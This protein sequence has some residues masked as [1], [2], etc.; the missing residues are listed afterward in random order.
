MSLQARLLLVLLSAVLLTTAIATA[1]TYYWARHEIDELFDYHLRQQALTLRDKA[2]MLGTVVVPEPDPDQDFVI[3]AWDWRGQRIYLSHRGVVLPRTAQPGYADLSAAGTDWRVYTVTL[4]TQ[5]VQIAQPMHVRRS[6]ATDAALKILYPLL[7]ILPVLALLIWWL[8]GRALTPL[9]ALARTIAERQPHTLIP[10]TASGLPTEA[11]LMV[12]AL[13]DLIARL[14]D[15]LSRQ[16]EFMADAAHELRTPLTALQLQTQLLERVETAD[17]RAAAIA[18]LKAGVQRASHL[19]ERLLTFTR[20]APESHD[21]E[22]TSVD[23]ARMAHEIVL[24]FEPSARAREQRLQAAISP[25]AQINGNETGL[26]SLLSNLLDNA[27]HSTPAGGVVALDVGDD[28]SVLT[29]RVTDTGPGIPVAE[30]ERIFDRFYRIA[31]TARHGSGLGLAIVKRVV[32]LHHG[33]ITVGSGP[34]G[35]G[36]EFLVR[37]PRSINLDPLSFV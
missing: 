4:G 15:V 36:A 10:I 23:V 37:L 18:E 9:G 2:Y 27:L 11:R 24:R 28:P 14:R 3:Q 6:L 17:A 13:N 16:R 19:I 25:T 20:L 31:G 22:F 33:E 7:A 29:L 30:R 32:D 5:L 8:V 35:V 1:A 34:G 21:Q 26:Q 12:D